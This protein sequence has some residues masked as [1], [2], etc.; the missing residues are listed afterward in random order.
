MGLSCNLRKFLTLLCVS[1]LAGFLPRK[2][3]ITGWERLFRKQLDVFDGKT[4]IRVVTGYRH[5]G[6]TGHALEKF[7]HT[8]EVAWNLPPGEAE[9]F[10]RSCA[11][12]ELK[13]LT[14]KVE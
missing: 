9:R 11:E 3:R 10:Y 1:P 4:R 14:F 8:M 5:S 12:E 13:R 7:F 6:K 2:R